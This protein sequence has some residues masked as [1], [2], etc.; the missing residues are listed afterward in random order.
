MSANVVVPDEVV[1]ALTEPKENLIER[2]VELAKA[3]S[4]NEFEVARLAYT[5]HKAYEMRWR[6]L[7]DELN[8]RGISSYT[9]S[10]LHRI[11]RV[12]EWWVVKNGYSPEHLLRYS[13]NKLYYLAREKV[14]DISILDEYGHLTDGR[15]LAMLQEKKGV[16]PPYKVVHVPYAA[17]ERLQVVKE[18][19]NRLTGLSASTAMAIEFAAEVAAGMSEETFATLW[20]ALHGELSEEEAEELI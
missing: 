1:Q 13:K 18:R 3:G 14:D 16:V 20:K 15:F 5:L 6:E 9:Y 11:G 8:R 17:Y 12:Y 4:E 2:I 19:I 10:W 7:A